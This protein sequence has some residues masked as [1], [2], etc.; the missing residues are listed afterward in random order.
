ML[1]PFH[2]NLYSLWL[3]RPFADFCRDLARGRRLIVDQPPRRRPL[4]P[5]ARVHDRGAD[6]RRPCGARRSRLATPGNARHRGVGCDRGTLRSH[7]SGACR[8]ARPLHAVRARRGGRGGARGGARADPGGACPLRRARLPRGARRPH[9][10][11]MGGRPRV[12]GMV[13]LAPPPHGDAGD[14]GG[15]PADAGR[16]RRRRRPADDP[17][18]NARAVEGVRPRGRRGGRACDPRRRSRR[19][20]GDRQRDLRERLRPRSDRVVPAG[21]RADAGPGL[22][23]RD[24]PFHRPGRRRRNAP[25]S[26]ATIVGASSWTSTGGSSGTSWRGSAARSSTPP[27]TASSRRSTAPPARSRAPAPSSSAH[28]GSASR[29]APA[30]TRASAS[31]R[32]GSSRDWRSTS[33]HA[34][35]PRPTRGKSWSPGPSAIS[36]PDRAS[37]STTSGSGS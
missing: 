19:P 10:P 8:A 27:A 32:T 2:S 21:D 33:G 16:P 22:G 25:S 18:P 9:Q 28:A 3:R 36:S 12:P 15:V 29:S 13:R 20:A 34:C 24:A 23:A 30:S 37:R 31:A 5:H 1:L 6:G 17:R 14:M 7:V 26:S 35:S 4:R 11:A